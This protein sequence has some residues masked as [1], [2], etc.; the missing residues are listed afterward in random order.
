MK[1]KILSGL[2]LIP[3]T[4]TSISNISNTAYAAGEELGCAK[5]VNVL[6]TTYQAP[7][8]KDK[9]SEDRLKKVNTAIERNEKEFKK[10]KE[11]YKK[12][13]EE[14]KKIQGNN[15]LVKAE[16]LIK[17]KRYK[18]ASTNINKAIKLNPQEEKNYLRIAKNLLN[19]KS[20]Q[21]GKLK[22]NKKEFEKLKKEVEKLEEKSNKKKSNSKKWY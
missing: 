12:L 10:L 4:L 13:K 6:V 21:P 18:E 14:Y 3:L 17:L 9:S 5:D 22:E 2:A 20:N 19:D 7:D 1:I 16:C 15:F 11:E 8:D